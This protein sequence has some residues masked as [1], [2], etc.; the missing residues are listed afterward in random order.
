M[1]K[2]LL[3]SVPALMLATGLAGYWLL[4]T[5][6]GRDF[7]LRQLQ[8]A[9]PDGAR[10]QW[11]QVDGHLGG[12]LQF[13][14][15]VYTDATQR[16]EADRLAFDLDVPRL[17]FR[18]IRIGSLQAEQVALDL[19]RDDTP[20]EFPQWPGSLPALDLPF[21]LSVGALR[22]DGLQIAQDRQPLYALR[23]VTG[24]FR[25]QPGALSIPGLQAESA[26]GRIALGGFYQP[27]HGYATRLHGKAELKAGK[28]GH[29]P[30]LRFK[31]DGDAERFLLGVEG[32]M[33]EPVRAQWRLSNREGRPHWQLTAEATRF[34]PGRLGFADQ[35]VY[36][37]DVRASGDQT[38]ITAQG[39]LARDAEEL[40]LKPSRLRFT[41]DR[42]LLEQVDALY[43]GGSFTATGSIRT[44][45]ELGSDGLRLNI[46]DFPLPIAAPA[47]KSA[48]VPVLSAVLR[49][50]GAVRA[51]QA[52]AEGELL[53]GKDTARFRFSGSGGENALELREVDVRT[54]AGGLNGRLKARWRPDVELAFDGR[55]ARFD[56]A[57]FFPAF[58]GAVDADL[59]FSAASA[60]D[61]PW[62]G[63]LKVERLGGQLRGRPL[64]GSADLRYRGLAV[65]GKADLRV[66]GS[67]VLLEGSGGK[68][69]DVRAGLQPLD[70]ADINPA[71]GGRIEGQA[72]LRGDPA[73]PQYVLALQARD[74]RLP[75]Y[76]IGR[77]SVSGDTITGNRTELEAEDLL[78][79]GQTIE[80]LALDMTGKPADAAIAV[81]AGVGE[82]T[83]GSAMRMRWRSGRQDFDIESLRIDAGPA[84]IWNLKSPSSLALTRTGY[85]FTPACLV[86][87]DKGAML[88]AEDDDRDIVLRSQDF[89]LALAEP[90]LNTGNR[91]F[92]YRGDIDIR[93]ELPKDFDFGRSGFVDIGVPVLTVGLRANAGTEVTRIDGLQLRASWQNRRLGA[94]LKAR[95]QDDGFIDGRL[96]TGFAPDAPLSG[97]L[98]VRM[99]RLDWL[100]LL[101]LD[102]AQPSGRLSGEVTLGGTRG[103]PLFNGAYRLQDFSVEIP[104]LG[105]RLN[106][107]QLTAKSSNNLAMLIKGSIRSGEGRVA[108]TGVWDPAGQL[109]QPLDLRLIGKN[110]TLADT[111]DMQLVADIDVLFG[112]LA[113][114][115]S[116]QG[117]VHLR[118][119]LLNLQSIG[120]DVA[121]S[122]DVVVLDPAPQR[123]GRDL[124]RLSVNLQVDIDD[125]LRV[126]GFGLDGTVSGRLVVN[127]PYDSPT[128]LTGA[129]DLQGT[130]GTYGQ[131][132]RIKRG[133][134]QYSNAAVEQPVLDILVEREIASENLTVGLRI[135]GPASN[136]KTQVLSS[137]GLPENEALSW[138]MFGQPLNNVS[139][140]DA[141][142]VNAKSM[143][144]NA[145]GS[146]LVGTLGQKIGLDQAS[147]TSTRALGDSTLTIGEQI[148]P[149]F[150]VSYGVSLL[151]IG[152]IITLKYLLF[153][154]FDI[155]IE[156]E[157]S[158]VRTQN[159]AALN[160]RR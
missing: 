93:A 153:K 89:P 52:Q 148:S 26:D 19:P 109:E 29:R 9:L 58:P 157:Q 50:S 17:L 23:S 95:L 67:H 34:E 156:S 61:S 78:L 7:A 81:S 44:H 86:E 21:S 45:G 91:D 85:A 57:Y 119:G 123:A 129:L 140:G 10:L 158:Q 31:A 130:Y 146:Y 141:Q 28:G 106:D 96:E 132:L 127:S 126:K 112:H 51:W 118:N 56:P 94:T 72:Q 35:G 76:R 151:G 6:A 120:V 147:V 14:K 149:R 117:G 128:R 124:L 114:V 154:G 13:R 42:L 103:D 55:M 27:N 69:L 122:P 155:T 73:M 12:R 135:T 134:I 3:W 84:G 77:L 131:R 16:H 62:Q 101:T 36:R 108:V 133:N 159:S 142:A 39:E 4:G 104:G 71:W 110:V 107:G 80:R 18:E 32:A 15:L 30:V 139:A 37:F 1:L 49:V 22:I 115:Y 64:A 24:G 136:P 150:F 75:S 116:M 90:W 70:L 105:L 68:R 65:N 59:R 82:F 125:T 160:W 54:A 46:R 145:G 43:G 92:V 98:E 111:P 113:G 63:L 79:D 100:E 102:I 97:A 74:V 11:R 143:A 87:A 20:F 8:G 83:I 121:I 88:C 138:L 40:V 33:P 5:D 60:A 41:R 137:T 38:R 144:L 2:L 53:R 25:L 47:G 99:N 152:Q 48:P 66:G